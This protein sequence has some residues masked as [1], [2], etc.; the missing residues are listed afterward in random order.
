MSTRTVLPEWLVRGDCCGQAWKILPGAAERGEAFT[1]LDRRHMQV[2]LDDDETARCIRAHELMHAKISP[3]ERALPDDK[4]FIDPGLL[5]SAEEFRVNQLIR[6][7]GFPVGKHL[8][9]GSEKLTG[10][11]MAR[12]RN[13]RGLVSAVAGMSGTM[14]IRYLLAGV[15]EVSKDLAQSLRLLDRALQTIWRSWV[16]PSDDEDRYFDPRSPI[17]TRRVASTEP[18]AFTEGGPV[19]TQ[20]WMFTIEIAELLHLVAVAG[21]DADGHLEDLR[22]NR[23]HFDDNSEHVVGHFANLVELEVR[24]S[25]RVDGTLGRRRRPST[26]GRHPRRINR[27]LADP[28]RRVF[29]RREPARGGVVL[30]DQSGSMGLEREDIDRLLDAAPGCTVIGYSHLSGRLDHPNV[31]VIAENGRVADLIPSGN[32]GNGVDGPAIRFAAARRRRRSEPFIWVSDGYVTDFNDNSRLNLT[33][34]CAELVVTHGIHQV[35]YMD[36]A[37]AALESA[38]RGRKL[39]VVGVG[40]IGALLTGA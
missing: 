4:S 39:P 10:R 36:E 3:R 1:D 27:M 38:G 31:W 11:R 16:Q 24:R 9:D 19:A 25:R 40:P 20:G 12:S 33:R 13:W 5:E 2:P 17:D 6:V 37:L 23:R 28:E 30:I 32:T 22:R 8:Y 35:G 21:T 18:L 29:D 7:A 26:N 34:E 15:S 14:S